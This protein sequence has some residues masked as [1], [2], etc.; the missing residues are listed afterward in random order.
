MRDFTPTKPDAAV[1]GRCAHPLD[2]SEPL[3]RNCREFF[4]RLAGGVAIR[5]I[6]FTRT[7][8]PV[9]PSS[10]V[11]LQFYENDP[12]TWFSHVLGLFHFVRI[13]G[14]AIAVEQSLEQVR[15]EA[16]GT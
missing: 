6:P 3:R 13:V 7:P 4:R 9:A 11:N 16:G 1:C 10:M 12:K 2:G 15:F 14:A 5:P 8:G